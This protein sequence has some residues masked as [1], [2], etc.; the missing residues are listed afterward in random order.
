MTKFRF[1]LAVLLAV[2][3]GGIFLFDLY[4]YFTLDFFR[5]QQEDIQSFVSANLLLSVGVFFFVYVSVTAISLPVGV[6][7]SL[8]AGAL[9]GVALGTVVVSFAST[10]GASLAFLVSRFLLQDFV[11]RH[12]PKAT[13]IV[14]AGIQ[15]DG[16]YYLFT[17]RLVPIFPY[18]VINLAMGLTHISVWTF[19]W[20]SQ[21][22]LLP[23]TLVL[24]NAGEQISLVGSFSDV[25]SPVLMGSLVLVGLFPLLAKKLLEGLQSRKSA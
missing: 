8:S 4:Q 24:T 13:Q 23:I 20:I 1:L 14:N 17:L 9:F 12:F 6:M 5:E 18:F 19:A 16:A 11:D 3:I 22:G 15:R 2:V 10:I 7:L 21:L 25:I